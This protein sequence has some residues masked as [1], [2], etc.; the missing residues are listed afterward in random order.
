MA[1]RSIRA[2]KGAGKLNQA[3]FAMSKLYEL[4]DGLS[5]GDAMSVV[6]SLHGIRTRGVWQ[7]DLVP[8]LALA[9]LVPY[10]LDYGQFGAMH[11]A[12][13]RSLDAQV[14]WLVRE[15]DRIKADTGCAR[16]SVIAHSF[17]TLQLGRL[18]Q[19][20][21]H[22]I[23][24]KVIL[25]AGILPISY[26]WAKMLAKH[27][28]AWVVNDYGGNDL[29]PRL[30]RYVIRFA[31]ECGAARF[32]D[33]HR[34]L[35][36]VE[37]PHHGHSDYFSLGN[38]RHHWIPTLLLD[39]RSMVDDLHFLLGVL[40]KHYGMNEKRLRCS[41]LAELQPLAAQLEVIGGVQAGELVNGELDGAV[42]FTA[43]G[44]EAGPAIAFNH[45]R[46][47][48]LDCD[49]LQRLRESMGLA[50][51]W[52]RDL[53]WALLLPVPTAADSTKAAAVV[54]LEGLDPPSPE[55]LEK[56]LIKNDTV[57]GILRRLGANLNVLSTQRKAS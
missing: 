52:H 31:G 42:P 57:T 54:R 2:C 4:S 56:G 38:F 43:V 36:Q 5:E 8:E 23:F 30:A 16:P 18:L 13:R 35:H 14:E 50:A 9:G 6:I 7:N 41:V 44:P 47:V 21:D 53:K 55:L 24:D 12:A 46:E 20:H 39:K 15:Y 48:M 45:M 37:H 34:G 3:E 29:W 40:A 25:A 32:S 28:V 10:V 17:G 49:D 51:P 26:P 33:T 1:Q 27:R 11:L 19:K 22:V